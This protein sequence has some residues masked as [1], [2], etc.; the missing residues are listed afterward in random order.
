M[1]SLL[2]L[3][4][5]LRNQILVTLFFGTQLSALCRHHRPK[6]FQRANYRILAANKQLHHEASSILFD[7][8][9]LRFDVHADDC[10]PVGPPV[11]TKTVIPVWSWYVRDRYRD[12]GTDLEFLRRW[13][14]LN[15]V[16]HFEMSPFSEIVP[17]YLGGIASGVGYRV[18]E[19]CKMVVRFL[20][21]LPDVES[22]T[23]YTDADGSLRVEGC[24]EMFRGMTLA[25]LVILGRADR[26]GHQR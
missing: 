20:N 9:V 5:E 15:R 25:K 6:P 16:R 1:P 21:E 7:G 18:W 14:G 10:P 22:L 23:V 11:V 4:P 17:N 19:A 13:Q 26:C 12:N 24:K 3:P 2:A 8:A